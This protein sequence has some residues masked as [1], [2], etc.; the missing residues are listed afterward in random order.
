[1]STTVDNRVVEMRFDN[2]QFESN[3]QTSLSTLDKLKSSLNMSGAAKGLDDINASARGFNMSGMGSAVDAVKER[4]SALQVMA[5]TALA[6]ITN[7]AVNAGKK[8]LSSFTIEP[9]KQG[10]GEYELKMNSVQ[11]IMASTGASVETVNKYLNELNEYADKTIYSFSDMTAN[12]GKFTNSGV[13]LD[14]SVAAIQGISNV[15]AVSGAN[16]NEASRAM[17]NFAQALA[18]G[19]VKAIDW[20]SIDLANMGTMEFKQQLIDTAV[21][22]GTVVKKGDK[23]VSTTKDAKGKTSEAFTASK[24]FNESLSSQ[25]MTTDVLIE[26]LGHY[27]ADV[28]DMTKAEKEEY[29]LQLKK[30]GFTAKQIKEIEKLGIKAADSAKVVKTFSQMIDTTKE[31]IGTGWSDTFEIIFG[32]FEEAKQLWTG[33]SDV[34]G[35]FINNMS[36]ARNNLLQGW[37]DLGGRTA[38]IEG[39]KNAFTGI[40]TVIKPIG[41]AFRD[42]FPP[43]TAKQ[44][45]T[46]SKNFKEFTSHMKLGKTES[47]NL[48]RTFK[49]L[50]AVIDM[51][52]RAFLTI[53]GALKPV[54]G[55]LGTLGKGVLEVTA[56]FGDFLVALN[57]FLK[58]GLDFSK[59]NVVGAMFERIGKRLGMVES[60]FKKGEKSSSGF[61]GAFDK[62]NQAF[63]TFKNF[64]SDIFSGGID[65]IS[66]ALEKLK[67]LAVDTFSNLTD[68]FTGFKS[69]DKSG[70]LDGFMSGFVDKL[71]NAD[72]SKI[73]DLVNVLLTGSLIVGIKK[74][75]DNFNKLFS[76]GDDSFIGG[77]IKK[78]FGPIQNALKEFSGIGK[79]IGKKVVGSLDGLLGC[80]KAYQAQLKATTLIKIAAAIAI[81]AAS[82]IA[83]SFVDSK[84]LAVSIGALTG[85]FANLTGVMFAYSKFSGSITNV[86]K[87]TT[88]MIGISV[89]LL[90]MA[91]A[92]KKVSELNWSQLGVG[93]SGILG[94]M[95]IMVASVKVLGK[96]GNSVMKGA[97][98]LIMLAVALKMIASVCEQLSRLKP[99]ELK[100]GLIG[101]GSLLAGIALFLQF[102]KFNTKV[103]T[104]A[105]GIVILAYALKSMADVCGVFTSFN[106]DEIIRGLTGVGGVLLFIVGFSR[107][108]GKPT[109][110]LSAAVSLGAIGK[111]MK[112]LAESI[113]DMSKLTW[114]Q[115][116][117]GLVGLGVGLVALGL[118]LKFMPKSEVLFL[119][120]TIKALSKAMAEISTAVRSMSTLSWEEIA[121][122][123]AGI[124]GGLVILGLAL[125]FMPK[126]GA[127]ILGP[128]IS[129]MAKSISELST[130][131]KSFSEMSWEQLAVG[132][133]GLGGSLAILAGAL[134]LMKESL[135]GSAAL[136]VAAVALSM[137]APVL[138]TL[139][140]L[141]WEAIA[142]G[143]VAIAGAFAVIGVA[144]LLLGP[145]V[146]ALLGIGAAL[147]LV[148]AGFLAFGAGLVAAGV[149]LGLIAAGFA[150]LALTVSTSAV[151]ITTG[152]RTIIGG[153][154][155]TIPEIAGKLGEGVT[156]FVS[157]IAEHASQ[158]A[159][160][161]RTVV[162]EFIRGFMETYPLLIESA[163]KLITTFLTGLKDNIGR[164]IQTGMEVVIAFLQGIAD[165]IQQ[166]TEKG[167][168]IVL[169]FI[170]GVASKMDAIIDSAFNLIISFIDG[171]AKAIDKNTPRLVASMRKLILAAIN[172]AIL[173]V[174]GGLINVK[175]AGEKFIK[176]GLVKGIKSKVA[177]V[178]K[179][180]GNGI[181]DAVKAVVSFVGN[182]LEAG[183]KLIGSLVKGVKDKGSEVK[184][185]AIE[186][187]SKAASAV[188]KKVGEWANA[189]GKL[190]EG[191]VKGIKKK[192]DGVKRAALEL[193]EKAK[194]ALSK[195]DFLYSA[196]KSLVEGFIK[197]IKSLAEKAAD[198]V[199]S[200]GKKAKAAF[201]KYLKVN[202]P[203]KIFMESGKSVGEG[204]ILGMEK[205][206]GP[207][208][209]TSATIANG[210]IDSAATALNTGKE[211]I[212]GF[213][214]TLSETRKMK[215]GFKT[216]RGVSDAVE[217]LLNTG[218]NLAPTIRPVLDLSN[219]KSGASSIAG[220][221]SGQYPIAAMANVNGI[222]AVMNRRSGNTN[223]DVV[224]AINT[225]RK[226]IGNVSGNSYNFGNISYDDGSSVSDAVKAL[227]RAIKVERRV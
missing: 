92:M 57:N 149:G 170:D 224:D 115:L 79:E 111:A 9:I 88:A 135:A 153:I 104:T 177:E 85:L 7:S 99:D 189:A 205:Q 193:I 214:T 134:V 180:V 133:V 55:V 59:Y 67:S 227:V 175:K 33:V 107:T 217:S 185:K 208:T 192:A 128:M 36:T 166:A 194:N 198:V 66:N 65:K 41:Q 76:L 52:K 147:V 181:K 82:V 19:S 75:I 169:G 184:N 145:V 5:V 31:A 195:K 155:Q 106:M 183:A 114:D 131:L 157:S 102:G 210:A 126:S 21:A 221:L 14:K 110:L 101:V 18:S 73:F 100:T 47:E 201:D 22:M 191:F 146:P 35:G 151:A 29:E 216:L 122:G 8:L 84:K 199:V 186:L 212:S 94:L 58:N 43:I 10:F 105:A 218:D 148:G 87:T 13:S 222:S 60:G 120:Y 207:V 215:S 91:G 68:L 168:D 206:F 196:G 109:V 125:K 2:Q 98:Q 12:I 121:R 163:F 49:G 202:S 144:G 77:F 37:K 61:L 173:V 28:R 190:I 44:L 211:A 136:L 158:L 6:N 53:L 209:K 4:F 34:I 113:S 182:W 83:L 223:E 220:L 24:M 40:A 48:K 32:N 80:L 70:G 150:A 1:M 116:A 27:S 95:G 30:Q 165:N 50:F 89:A 86:T 159:T 176:S 178:A 96:S 39:L 142:K 45:F 20:K 143:L 15:A 46:L 154:A 141:S 124:G 78:T 103:I 26:T 74:L 171:L 23:Y 226:E 132:L 197:G 69:G 16:T 152:M 164:I 3:V 127:F 179:T 203:S 62:L 200:I 64:V 51:G 54:L 42:I 167:V 188:A 130:V 108:V 81:L 172:A 138:T 118:T 72:F 25:W 129:T 174:T 97:T 38:V 225:L 17:Y 162:E 156:A 71:K 93:L 137:I 90:I 204:F 160:A 187:V 11:T 123:L 161:A 140:G 63:D 56:A 117:R 139:G 112:T 119:A 213:I 219:V